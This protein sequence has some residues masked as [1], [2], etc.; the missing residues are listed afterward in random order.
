MMIQNVRDE[1]RIH[2]RE[3]KS[4]YYLI[5][6]AWIESEQR[7]SYRLCYYLKFVSQWNRDYNNLDKKQQ[8]TIDVYEFERVIK[9]VQR[10]VRVRSIHAV[11]QIIINKRRMKLSGN[12]IKNSV[13]QSG[14]FP[15]IHSNSLAWSILGATTVGP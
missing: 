6:T 2:E 14:N 8:T 12:K 3:R 4:I 13:I 15:R 11:I 10:E 9:V 1:E 7:L 5:D